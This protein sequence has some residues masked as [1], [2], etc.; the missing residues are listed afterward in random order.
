MTEKIITQG[1]ELLNSLPD[2]LV[3][4]IKNISGEGFFWKLGTL[5]DG[6]YF[7]QIRKTPETHTVG[8]GNSNRLIAAVN[9]AIVELRKNNH[10]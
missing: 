1:S 9:E 3:N 2:S 6:S 7:A 4:E 8:W 10:G 5:Q